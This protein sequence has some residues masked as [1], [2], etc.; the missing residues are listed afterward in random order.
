MDPAVFNAWSLT[1]L[2]ALPPTY[3][4]PAKPTSQHPTLV[5]V[6][7]ATSSNV[8]NA[9][10]T[11]FAKLAV[12]TS[13]FHLPT[14]NASVAIFLTASVAQLEMMFVMSVKKVSVSTLQAQL[15]VISA[16]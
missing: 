3:V 6:W 10:T 13:T 11:T 16:M 5:H 7:L 4:P 8:L 12:K 2:F 15:H 9:N 14:I 1:A